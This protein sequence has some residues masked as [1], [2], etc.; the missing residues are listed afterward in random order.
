[1]IGVVETLL[2]KGED[3]EIEGYRIY[4][5]DREGEGGGVMLAIKEKYKNLSIEVKKENE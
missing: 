3:C 4:R 2:N 1:M 5:N